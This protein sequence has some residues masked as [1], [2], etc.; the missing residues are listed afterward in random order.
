MSHTSIDLAIPAPAI[1]HIC[2]THSL[3]T[4]FLPNTNPAFRGHNSIFTMCTT[5]ISIFHLSWL[6]STI[7]LVLSEI[8]SD[9]ISSP[10]ST[11]RFN[12]LYL[13][14]PY[15]PILHIT[16]ICVSP[17]QFQDPTSRGIIYINYYE[18]GVPPSPLWLRTEMQVQ[19]FERLMLKLRPIWGLPS[20][21]IY[22]SYVDEEGSEH[23]WLV[24][25]HH[26]VK[27]TWGE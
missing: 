22:F 16:S 19:I 23:F 11:I 15:I 9:S 2:H 1:T 25:D 4:S 8:Q 17:I 13:S 12:H 21:D 3:P 27:R 14:Q 18:P 7:M 6:P 20:P 10:I 26:F 5:D 24:V